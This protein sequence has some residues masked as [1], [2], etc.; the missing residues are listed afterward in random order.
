MHSRQ[1]EDDNNEQHQG[2]QRQQANPT[3]AGAALP[4]LKGAGWAAL[5]PALLF[6]IPHTATRSG[7]ADR[8]WAA[9]AKSGER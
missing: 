3:E 1:L 8:G 5:G 9:A 4:A 7:R 2:Q 6:R